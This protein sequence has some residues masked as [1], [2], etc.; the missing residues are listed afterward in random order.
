MRFLQ[1]TEHHVYYPADISPTVVDNYEGWL[2]A[3]AKR[4]KLVRAHEVSWKSFNVIIG[5][6]RKRRP[7]ILHKETVPR[8]MSRRN[9]GGTETQVFKKEK[10]VLSKEHFGNIE[11]ICREK[12]D[13]YRSYWLKGKALI[14]DAVSL[15]F[16]GTMLPESSVNHLGA[17]LLYLKTQWQITGALGLDQS[18]RRIK[19][20]DRKHY[21]TWFGLTSPLDYQR[22]FMPTHEDLLPYILLTFSRTGGNPSSILNLTR[23]CL[24]IPKV[25]SS[26]QKKEAAF[27]DAVDGNRS[28][29]WFLKSKTGKIQTRSYDSTAQYAPTT[30]ISQVLEMTE[31]AHQKA[32]GPTRNKLWVFK[33]DHDGV[34][35]SREASFTYHLKALIKDS[36]L[37][38]FT[39]R[40]FRN[41]LL[42]D[43]VALTGNILGGQTLAGHSSPTTMINDYLAGPGRAKQHEI[44]AKIQVSMQNWVE[45]GLA[46]RPSDFGT[47]STAKG[48]A[49]DAIVSVWIAAFTNTKLIVGGSDERALKL[50]QMKAHL[51]SARPRLHSARWEAGFSHLLALVNELLEKFEP[52]VLQVAE[53]LINI[54]GATNPLPPIE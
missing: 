46:P 8:S 44:I 39:V 38:G 43:A 17:V 36:K 34:T 54:P 3:Y 53:E 4:E 29:M 19:L 11:A 16:D 27:I 31:T 49:I 2:K 26:T 22:Y 15:G 7:E 48:T 23:D 24:S 50:L 32:T 45:N 9:S 42:N 37:K 40:H 1:E 6:L 5:I 13:S 28:R 25:A 52:S 47:L 10:T 20:N 35:W 41:T 51:M 14:E 18:G 12:V 33:G 30:L 21:I